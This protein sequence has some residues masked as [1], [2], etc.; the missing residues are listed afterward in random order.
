MR[1]ERQD[2]A[3]SRLLHFRIRLRTIRMAE[4]YPTWSCQA[5]TYLAVLFPLRLQCIGK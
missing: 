4:L 1:T 5:H 2:E 3:N